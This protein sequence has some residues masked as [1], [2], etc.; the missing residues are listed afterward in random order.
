MEIDVDK[1]EAEKKEE[2]IDR[3]ILSEFR[4]RALDAVNDIRADMFG[5]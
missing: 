5:G 2:V 3:G 4:D 1:F